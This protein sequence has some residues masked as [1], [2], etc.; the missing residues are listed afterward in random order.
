MLKRPHLI[1]ND[2]SGMKF[3]QLSSGQFF[4]TWTVISSL[5]KQCGKMWW[6]NNLGGKKGKNYFGTFC[7]FGGTLVFP[8]T[9]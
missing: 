6:R 2:L 1:C 7:C 9:H 5:S 3:L 8:V 4:D